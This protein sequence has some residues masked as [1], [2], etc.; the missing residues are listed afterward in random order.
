MVRLGYCW[1]RVV[2]EHHQELLP[3]GRRSVTSVRR[4]PARLYVALDVSQRYLV[5][6][7][8]A[9]DHVVSW[10]SDLKQ[11]A[12]EDVSIIRKPCI[13]IS[14]VARHLLIRLVVAN[15]TD[16]CSTS[17][18]SVPQV[19]Y[20][21]PFPAPQAPIRLST[22][23][24]SSQAAAH[25]APPQETA[26]QEAVEAEDPARSQETNPNLKPRAVSTL[27]GVLF[28][29]E[30]GLLYVETSAKE[31]WGVVDAFE[32]TAREVLDRIRGKQLGKKVSGWHA[33]SYGGR[34]SGHAD[35]S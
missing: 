12:D 21:Q 16:L 14:R 2:P 11:H 34:S 5:L 26:D 10:L 1:H 17:S 29:R 18:P 25:S 8:P 31:G 28:A 23:S 3:R 20:G 32:W 9:F 15:K 4:D 7:A 19:Q 22:S 33:W 35:L 13:R 27:D 24:G 6:T 30:H